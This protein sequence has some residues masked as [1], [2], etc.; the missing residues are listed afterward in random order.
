MK[1]K[2]IRELDLAT[3]ETLRDM[4]QELSRETAEFEEE[5]ANPGIGWERRRTRAVK[6]YTWI[7]AMRENWPRGYDREPVLSLAQHGNFIDIYS[8]KEDL[9]YVE[10]N[11][12]ALKADLK[13]VKQEI[14]R[15]ETRLPRGLVKIHDEIE[16]I[17]DQQARGYLEEASRC[18]SVEAFRA[19]VVMSGCALE[20]RVRKIYERTKGHSSGK[21]HFSTLIDVLEKERSISPDESA[22]LSICKSFRNLTAHPSG[23]Q[24]TENEAESLLRLSIEQ[25]KK[26]S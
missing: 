9:G 20:S 23:F 14:A 6:V 12:T 1:E 18:L 26:E 24:C 10:S 8:Q 15:M 2:G 25:L 3:Y 5:L 13:N 22:I 4:L 21:M 11:L 7:K 16:K 19:S 17:Q